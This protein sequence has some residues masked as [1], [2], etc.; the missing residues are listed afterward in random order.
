VSKG[1]EGV[2]MSKLEQVYAEELHKG[3]TTGTPAV[4]VRALIEEALERGGVDKADTSWL[5]GFL[6]H[7]I[8]NAS[9]RVMED[10]SVIPEWSGLFAVLG[11]FIENRPRAEHDAK[12]ALDALDLVARAELLD[13]DPGEYLA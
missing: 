11:V 4:L 6:G 7:L 13:F 9:P 5:L 12:V 10:P 3:F 8:Q 1:K 2:S